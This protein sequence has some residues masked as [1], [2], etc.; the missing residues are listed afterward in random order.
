R[1]VYSNCSGSISMRRAVSGICFVSAYAWAAESS[2]AR[3]AFLRDLRRNW[4]RYSL[5][6]RARGALAGPRTRISSGAWLVE[7]FESW[8]DHWIAL[9]RLRSRIMTLAREE[10]GG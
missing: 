4:K 6:R 10:N 9:S 2:L 5:L 3:A 1:S 7:N 8:L